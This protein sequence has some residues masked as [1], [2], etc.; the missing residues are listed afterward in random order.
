MSS[1]GSQNN[2]EKISKKR[3]WD[4]E[5]YSRN[6]KNKKRRTKGYDKRVVILDKQMKDNENV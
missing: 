1:F 5:D 3:R 6:K 4:D 2:F